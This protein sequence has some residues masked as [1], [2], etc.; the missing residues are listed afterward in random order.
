MN[1]NDMPGKEIKKNGNIERKEEPTISI[2]TPFYD[3]GATLQE[4]ANSIL[5]QTYPYF[6]WI[7]I[8]DGSKDKES[9]KKLEAVEKLDERIKV[10]HKENGGPAQ[11]RDYGIDKSNSSSKY[12]YFLDCDDLIENTAL[13]IMYWTLETHKE[14]SFAYSSIINFGAYKYY[15]E[16]YFTLEE[17]IVRNI[18][19]INAMVK[20]ED[21]LEVGG[22][23]IKEKSMYE[24]WN[25]WLKLLAKGKIPIR[26]NAPLFWYRTSTTGE[27]SRARKNHDK[28][29]RLINST[30]K[31]IKEDVDV[32]QFPRRS[33]PIITKN[34]LNSMT[35]PKYKKDKTKNVMFLLENTKLN[36]DNIY[37][38]ETIKRFSNNGYNTLVIA[39]TPNSDNNLYQDFK[40]I[41]SG[42]YDMSNFLDTKD[43]PLFIDYLIKSRNIDIIFLNTSNLGYTLLPLIKEKYPKVKIIEYIVNNISE[44]SEYL[45]QLIDVT[46]VLNKEIYNKVTRKN[47]DNIVLIEEKILTKGSTG[48]SIDIEKIKKEHNIPSDKKIVSFIDNVSF[49]CRPDIFLIIASK[50]LKIRK[51]LLFIINGTGQMEKQIQEAINDES[52]ILLNLDNDKIYEISDLV[53][54]CSQKEGISSTTYK[55]LQKGIPVI[56]TDIE[57]MNEII[58]D[59]NGKLI[60]V[61]VD[62]KK[63]TI[64]SLADKYVEQIIEVLKKLDIYQKDAKEVAIKNDF[65]NDNL[66]KNL[67]D[68]INKT[69]I[70]SFK[71]D[72]SNIVYLYYSQLIAHDFDN[73]YLKYYK[74]KMHIIP[75][76]TVDRSKASML[77]KKIRSFSIKYNIENSMHYIFTKLKY[78]AVFIKSL[79]N[80]IK[81]LF[82]SMIYII[83]VI[84]ELLTIIVKLSIAILVKI[85]AK[86]I[87]IVKN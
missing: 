11:A 26:V 47:K 60:K 12:V 59:K 79:I 37:I 34:T 31:T 17:E 30:A 78:P 57:N 50:L 45:K 8:D 61:D 73:K 69:S 68:I 16:P 83:P 5:N 76:E 15:W 27:L 41:S 42:F 23:E 40:E 87:N 43:Y 14:A 80:A 58:N 51:D 74:D 13:E 38:Y 10:L 39:T 20:K 72:Y 7:I 81:N 85:K 52:I 77:K 2:I 62:D 86:I 49:E 35:L 44:Y 63:T 28:A 56:S 9:L 48:R 3:G 70:K 55:A 82:I 46:I 21:F 29:M 71:N 67:E 6:E 53:I 54:N 84:I 4:T 18:M 33:V 66:Y 36:K 24:D 1:F 64:N 19:C 75:R 65:N 22:F 25:L 32:I